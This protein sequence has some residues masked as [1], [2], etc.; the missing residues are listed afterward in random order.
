MKKLLLL[1]ISFMFLLS[2][3]DEDC[4]CNPN[5]PATNTLKGMW[6]RT[7]TDAQNQT[8]IVF[9]SFDGND[10]YAFLVGENVENHTNSYANY[11]SSETEITIF[12][13]TD[14]ETDG[15]YSYEINSTTLTVEEIEDDCDPRAVMLVGEWRRVD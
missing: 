15:S 1:F 8:F 14:C 3:C 4:D 11:S 7:V 2:A 13:D 10:E 9:I 6:E 12:N 5:S